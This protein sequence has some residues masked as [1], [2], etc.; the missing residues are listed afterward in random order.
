MA[1]WMNGSIFLTS[2]FSMY[3]NGSKFFT[4]AAKRTGNC[5]ASKRVI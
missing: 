1:K 5:E 2:F 4:S 3:F